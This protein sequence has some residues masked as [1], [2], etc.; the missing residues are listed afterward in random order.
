VNWF[1][2]IVHASVI[3]RANYI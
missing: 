2:L 1:E 3:E